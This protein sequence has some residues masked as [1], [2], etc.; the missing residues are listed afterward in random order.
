LVV[1]DLDLTGDEPTYEQG[2]AGISVDTLRTDDIA[3]VAYSQVLRPGSEVQSHADRIENGN[4]ASGV[5]GTILR[6][7][8]S[9]TNQD[10]VQSITGDNG[11][12]DAWVIETLDKVFT[13]DG[14]TLERIQSD[15]ESLLPTDDSVPTVLTVRC[16]INDTDLST[17]DN[18]DTDWF[19]PADLDVLNRAMRRRDGQRH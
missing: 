4:D 10:S 19:W 16:R 12:P 9:W 6:R 11:H 14:E 15:I 18:D 8:R 7:V 5:A 3:K 1:I 13:K 17:T 2:G